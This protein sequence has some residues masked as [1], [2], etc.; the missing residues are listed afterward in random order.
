VASLV[1]QMRS[2]GLDVDLQMEGESRDIPVGID[3]SAYRIVQEAP[4][5]PLKHAGHARTMVRVRYGG[6]SLELEIADD[7]DPGPVEVDRGG[8]GLVGMRER[9]AL[10][11]GTLDPGRR[12]AGGVG[13]R[14]RA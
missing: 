1:A 3:L 10:Y 11:G 14:A 13:V 6:D 2:A 4:T 12:P 7:G 8:H 9:V 5:T